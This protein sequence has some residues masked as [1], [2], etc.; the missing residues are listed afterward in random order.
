MAHVNDAPA[1]KKLIGLDFAKVNAA[2]M[3]S[4]SLIRKLPWDEASTP[5]RQARQPIF[6]PTGIDPNQN[7]ESINYAVANK[8][9]S[10][11]VRPGNPWTLTNYQVLRPGT[12]DKYDAINPAN[13][14]VIYGDQSATNA[15][16]VQYNIAH[17]Q[18]TDVYSI[19]TSTSF[20]DSAIV[21]VSEAVASFATAGW[22]AVMIAAAQNTFAADSGLE[23][24]GQGATKVGEA[25]VSAGNSPAGTVGFDSTTVSSG[26]SSAQ[27]IGSTPV[28]DFGMDSAFDSF[29]F[30][31]GESFTAFSDNE[32]TDF[33]FGQG[34]STDFLGPDYGLTGLVDSSDNGLGA[35]WNLGVTPE[36]LTGFGTLPDSGDFDYGAVDA[37]AGWSSGAGT[38]VMGTVA[39]VATPIVKMTGTG[40]ATKYSQSQASASNVSPTNASG[41]QGGAQPINN[42]IGLAG[43]L[44]TLLSKTFTGQLK[45]NTGAAQ[46]IA[47]IGGGN[48]TILLLGV[49][50]L[51]V[52]LFMK[53]KL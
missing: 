46:P 3:K 11:G 36:P 44:E 20:L 25:Y 42:A 15:I 1:L 49:G 47:S 5:K 40:A 43:Q 35:A 32:L 45:P 37:N 2:V 7:P 8:Y 26:V 21:I 38:S 33:G 28:A 41:T 24:W 19:G 18:I 27:E 48:N 39:K 16:F 52:A 30:S 9:A 10:W 4:G 53:G 22:S 17:G 14:L 50:L 34:T 6:I 31:D 29:D 23:T 51:A 12:T 13:D